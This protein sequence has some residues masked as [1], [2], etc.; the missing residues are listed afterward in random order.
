[1]RSKLY[2]V[3]SIPV[4]GLLY[5]FTA[6]VVLIILL[7]ALLHKKEIVR[8]IS[9]FWAKSVFIMIGKKFRITGKEN[10]SKEKQLY[11]GRQSWKSL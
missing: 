8:L 2:A 6:I 1:M 11:P 5:L 4:F 10:I 7:F 3:V 9:Q